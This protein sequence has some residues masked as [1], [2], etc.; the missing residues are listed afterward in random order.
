M[1]TES[2]NRPDPFA[3]SL[4]TFTI[5]LLGCPA[6]AML[7]VIIATIVCGRSAPSRSASRQKHVW[8]GRFEGA[9][10]QALNL[11][12]FCTNDTTLRLERPCRFFDAA[13]INLTSNP[14][15]AASPSRTRR[16]SSI[17]GS[18]G[19]T[20]S[21]NSSSGVHMTGHSHPSANGSK[22]FGDHRIGDVHA[23]PGYRELHA[24]N[25]LRSQCAQR[26]SPPCEG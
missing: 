15:L 14:C 18:L 12:F 7:L 24:V 17:M 5:T 19:M 23:I 25:S 20:Y 2:I 8:F 1:I 3:L 13:R 10:D 6:R 22:R 11:R 16:T 26:Q 9:S 4:P 21:P